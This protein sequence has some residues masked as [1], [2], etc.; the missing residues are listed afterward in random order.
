MNQGYLPCFS[1]Y[2]YDKYP[3]EDLYQQPSNVDKLGK[4]LSSLLRTAN[5]YLLTQDCGIGKE[6]QPIRPDSAEGKRIIAEAG[7]HLNLYRIDYGKTPFR[8]VFAIQNKPRIAYIIMIDTKHQTF[9]GKN[10]K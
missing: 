10:Q 4:L 1:C 6:I 3:I 5:P 8:I 9:S 2:K 7:T